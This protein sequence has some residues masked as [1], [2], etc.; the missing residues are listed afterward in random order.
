MLEGIAIAERHGSGHELSG[1]RD[2]YARCPA[3]KWNQRRPFASSDGVGIADARRRPRP[4]YVDRSDVVACCTSCCA[5][6]GQT[7]LTRPPRC[8]RKAATARPRRTEAELL[9]VL[10][11]AHL[12][13]GAVDEAGSA[14]LRS[15]W[16]RVQPEVQ[17]ER[18]NLGSVAGA[19]SAAALGTRGRG[20]VT[21]GTSLVGRRLPQ[22]A[23]GH[24]GWPLGVRVALALHRGGP[25]R[26]ASRRALVRRLLVLPERVRLTLAA[27]LA[28]DR[29]D[30]DCG[31][32]RTMRP[33]PRPGK[34][35]VRPMRLA[36]H[37][38]APAAASLSLGKVVVT[39]S[40][41]W[42]LGAE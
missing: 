16:R 24:K 30:S 39:R 10:V 41:R 3:A 19:G 25:S 42:V 20:G 26:V 38:S 2:A 11:A 23:D 13:S 29:A 40:L 14:S 22:R 27:L 28:E 34:P 35:G 36:W 5:A 7:R 9:A 17:E 18:L 31:R 37:C 6:D 32:R 33:P 12:G 1:L 15:T 4:G 21:T 8:S